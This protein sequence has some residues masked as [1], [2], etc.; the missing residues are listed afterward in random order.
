MPA[1]VIW[2]EISNIQLLAN[3]TLSVRWR[4]GRHVSIVRVSEYLL[5]PVGACAAISHLNSHHR[6][7]CNFHRMELD[8]FCACRRPINGLAF[9]FAALSY[10]RR[11]LSLTFTIFTHGY[12][13]CTFIV[14]AFNAVA[15]LWVTV[16]ASIMADA[17][18]FLAVILLAIAAFANFLSH[19]GLSLF[20][21]LD[22]F[23]SI[24]IL[25]PRALTDTRH[26]CQTLLQAHTVQLATLTTFTVASLD[27]IDIGKNPLTNDFWCL[28]YQRHD[29]SHSITDW[30]LLIF[31]L[32]RFFSRDLRRLFNL[33]GQL[34]DL[35]G[36]VRIKLGDCPC[37]LA[38]HNGSGALALLFRLYGKTM[39]HNS[40]RG[41]ALGS[42]FFL[43]SCRLPLAFLLL[44]NDHWLTSRYVFLLL[45]LLV[46]M[47]LGVLNLLGC[48]G[49]LP[50]P[51]DCTAPLN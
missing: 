42:H 14:E 1:N 44:R 17:I 45:Y 11:L 41:A 37:T 18:V 24:I 19:H 4:A 30:W 6:K 7:A 12:R 27:L 13:R 49:F 28:T 47:E 36:Q 32:C 26:T 9:R 34:I 43:A 3:C 48:W 23:F 31:E 33:Y 16:E 10:L 22:S 15:E 46:F 38:A 20:T 40:H 2:N 25:A 29:H 51:L 21:R 8:A 5:K 39:L 35:W 50:V